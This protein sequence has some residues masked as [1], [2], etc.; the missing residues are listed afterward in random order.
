MSHPD[1]EDDQSEDQPG[2]GDSGDNVDPDQGGG[3]PE[4]QDPFSALLAQLGINLPPGMQGLDFGTLMSQFG[5]MTGQPGAGPGMGFQAPGQGGAPANPNAEWDWLKDQVRKL[6]ASLGP[7]ATPSAAQKTQVTDSARLAEMW[8]D[9]ATEFPQVGA[10]AAVWSRAEWIEATFPSWRPLAEPVVS[11][12]AEALGQAPGGAVGGEGDPMAMIT[13]MLAPMM[14]D[15]ARRMYASQFAQALA[16]LSKSVVSASDLGFQLAK[17]RVA[18]LYSNIEEHFG[19]LDVETADV[20][21]YL[22]LREAAR[23]RLFQHVSWL[24]PQLQALVEHYARETRIDLSAI[25]D[26]FDFSDLS[27]RR[28]ASRC[29]ASCS[30]PPPRRSRRRC[31]TGCRRCSRWWRAGSTTSSMQL[32][33]AGCLRSQRSTRPCADAVDSAAPPRRSSRPSSGST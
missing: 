21:L 5:A 27:C 1:H 30:T 29:R 31:S 22:T 4:P 23:Q 24:G 6:S 13:S 15:A 14:R 10:P 17:P 2:Q 32:P 19:E 25:E 9:E 7:D 8:L 16:E 26:S 20:L 28:S 18:I 33:V 11:A 3:G 12:L